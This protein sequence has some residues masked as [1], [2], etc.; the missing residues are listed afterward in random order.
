M[1]RC[2]MLYRQ[3]MALKLQVCLQHYAKVVVIFQSKIRLETSTVNRC[4]LLLGV[5]YTLG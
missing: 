5:T 3:K 2:E 1:I 4:E